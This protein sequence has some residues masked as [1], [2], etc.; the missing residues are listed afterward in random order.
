MNVTLVLAIR[1]GVVA[2][3]VVVGDVHDA[4][5]K[6]VVAMV[7][8]DEDEQQQRVVAV[9]TA[10]L[11]RVHAVHTRHAASLKAGGVQMYR[12]DVVAGKTAG[13]R[14]PMEK[15]KRDKKDTDK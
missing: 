5:R 12:G 7:A 1:R 10:R 11:L 3:V 14:E 15:E 4:R 6:D 9:S 8:D 13:T 2:P